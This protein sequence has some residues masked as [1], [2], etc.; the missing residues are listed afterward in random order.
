MGCLSQPYPVFKQISYS[1]WHC[2]GLGILVGVEMGTSTLLRY[3]SR[4][5]L[6][7]QQLNH[8]ITKNFKPF[9]HDPPV[10]T[11]LDITAKNLWERRN[12]NIYAD[13]W[14]I[15][16]RRCHFNTLPITI[17]LTVK[18][19][20]HYGNFNSISDRFYQKFLITNTSKVCVIEGCPTLRGGCW[21]GW[22]FCGSIICHVSTGWLE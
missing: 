6:V 15:M 18:T 20:Y 17:S 2:L 8:L 16:H 11:M 10:V 3:F 19:R 21:N 14:E 22:G 9:Y 7:Y 12:P 1:K 13:V 5:A 4:T